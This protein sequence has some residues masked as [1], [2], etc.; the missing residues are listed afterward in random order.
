MNS[1]ASGPDGLLFF[2]TAAFSSTRCRPR[3]PAVDS[4]SV[5]VKPNRATRSI[6]ENSAVM[7]ALDTA[8]RDERVERRHFGGLHENAA[9]GLGR[10]N[11]AFGSLRD[12][13][14]T[15]GQHAAEQ[16]LGNQPSVITD[17][18]LVAGRHLREDTD[19]PFASL[20]G[21]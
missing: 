5:A 7:P 10:G 20:R 13:V 16:P 1:S 9:A 18:R 17:R 14:E 4:S 12:L 21:R 6:S 11:G 19:G 8:L 3:A 2:S 15:G